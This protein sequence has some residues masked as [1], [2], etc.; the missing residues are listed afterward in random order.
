RR[1]HGIRAMARRRAPPGARRSL[2]LFEAAV[3]G[4]TDEL[5]GKL[6]AAPGPGADEVTHALWGACHGGRQAAAA[7]LLERGADINWIGW[8]DLTALDVAERSDA[9][10]LA[11]WL[12]ER[13]GRSSADLA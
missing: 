7:L 12:R 10:E 3:M 2:D 13:G 8:D 9:S 1:C 6:A 4:L 5:Q 11:D